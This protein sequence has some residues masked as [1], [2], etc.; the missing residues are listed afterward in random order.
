MATSNAHSCPMPETDIEGPEVHQ[1][2][3]P[4]VDVDTADVQKPD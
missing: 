3:V 1:H 4:I 2:N